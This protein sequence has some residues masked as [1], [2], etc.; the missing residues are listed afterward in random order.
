MD[1]TVCALRRGGWKVA[2]Q[3]WRKTKSGQLLF[4]SQINRSEL[5]LYGGMT[6]LILSKDN[7]DTLLH[8]TFNN[9]EPYNKKIGVSRCLDKL[10]EDG[11]DSIVRG[12]NYSNIQ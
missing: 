7:Q 8:T 3:H 5:S 2:V 6:V 10:E 11:W 1:R 9:L 12:D 4:H